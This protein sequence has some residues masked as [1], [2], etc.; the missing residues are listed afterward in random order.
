MV[1]QGFLSWLCLVVSPWHLD[2]VLVVPR[3]LGVSMAQWPRKSGCLAHVLMPLRRRCLGG[4][5]VVCWR[6]LVGVQVVSGG[7]FSIE[8]AHLSIPNWHR[9]KRE[10]LLLGLYA[11]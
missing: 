1:S 2:G 11:G 9:K 6:C 4:V 5:S 10:A 7:I 3:C 8:L